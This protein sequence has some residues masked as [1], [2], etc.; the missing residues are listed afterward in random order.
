MHPA[1]WEIAPNQFFLEILLLL[2][3]SY[4]H[5]HHQLLTSLS[6]GH[7]VPRAQDDGQG[8]L[9]NRRG[10]DILAQSNVVADDLTQAAV[11][12][13]KHQTTSVP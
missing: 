4:H 7:E 11:L 5:H 13:L 10:L 9:L 2:F 6:A 3:F 12:K 1:C 8:K